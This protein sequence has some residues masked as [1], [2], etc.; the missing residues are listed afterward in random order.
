[1]RGRNLTRRTFQ[2]GRRGGSA[3]ASSSNSNP[4]SGNASSGPIRGRNLT[5]HG[6][7]KGERGLVLDNL[8]EDV[9]DDSPDAVIDSRT[10]DVPS[11][12]IVETPPEVV[13][14][15]PIIKRPIDVRPPKLSYDT[16]KSVLI[17]TEDG[18][19]VLE[20]PDGF[21][22]LPDDYEIAIIERG[23]L[24]FNN[25]VGTA[26][27][28]SSTPIEGPD[29]SEREK[30]FLEGLA[31][32][33]V[34]TALPGVNADIKAID[35]AIVQTVFPKS[36]MKDSNDLGMGMVKAGVLLSL[37]GMPTKG[38]GIPLQIAGDVI[39]DLNKED[40][41]GAIANLNP[42]VALGTDEQSGMIDR[43]VKLGGMI[44]S[45]MI[46]DFDAAGKSAA[47][48]PTDVPERKPSDH[49]DAIW[50]NVAGALEGPLNKSSD[51]IVKGILNPESLGSI[52]KAA[53]KFD[54]M[55]SYVRSLPD[56]RVLESD[57]YYTVL[58]YP[59]KG[60]TYIE[61]KPTEDIMN[62]FSRSRLRSTVREWGEDFLAAAG[63]KV[64][65]W[66]RRVN[67]IKDKYGMESDTVKHYGYSRGGGLSTH[68]GGT[69]YGTGY[70]SSY[71]PRKESKSKF[72]G[73]LLHDMIINPL[74]Y[75]LLI[76]KRTGI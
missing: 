54:D 72:S 55:S 28:D 57:R 56:I 43:K 32:T 35:E 36:G 27:I 61:W 19:P 26:Q 16:G 70:F 67:Y 49:I 9:P 21:E 31:E 42:I 33:F 3:P 18:R 69:G 53:S 29:E 22:N 4:S 71:L 25:E 10:E 37:P 75:A 47:T 38:I 60:I 51:T 39:L 5:R 63:H 44:G 15:E 12:P 2:D 62:L 17:S 34:E 74:S 76:R 6:Y 65:A 59:R 73:D 8:P 1:M 23:G 48:H 20:M 45:L 52:F 13:F 30:P 40:Y 14:S 58:F 66:T 11:E 7:N 50:G 24:G 41:T 64:P 46:G 68:L